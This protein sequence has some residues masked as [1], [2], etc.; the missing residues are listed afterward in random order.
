MRTRTKNTRSPKS[1]SIEMKKVGIIG[2][3]LIGGSFAISIREQFNVVEI[4]GLDLSQ[5]H[6]EQA[7]QKGLIDEVFDLD[8]LSV[9]RSCDLVFLAVPVTVICELLNEVLDVADY[10]TLVLDAGSTKKEICKLVENHPKRSQFLACHPIA[11]TEFSGPTAAIHDLFARK[12]QIIC[13]FDKTR[14]DL[15]QKALDLFEGMQM[16]IRY[17]DPVMHDK[18]LAYVSHLSHISS[19]ML[20]KTVMQLEPDEKNIFDMAGSG[21]EST[22]RLAKSSPEMWAPIFIQNKENVID[23]L[24]RYI[25]NLEQFKENLIQ[26]NEAFIR[27]E[28][29]DINSIKSILNRIP[30]N[31][32]SQ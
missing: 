4:I 20:G 12:I 17:M 24:E 1:Y 9:L 32:K 2:L 5:S 13:E 14:T 3:G 18:H 11:G 29:K 30:T 19:F 23:S 15:A 7:L 6:R 28:M 22:V 21:F 31:N 26:E 10:N 25:Q 27:T 8:D 16:K